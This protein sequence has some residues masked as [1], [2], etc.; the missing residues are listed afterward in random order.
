MLFLGPESRTG[1]TIFYPIDILGLSLLPDGNNFN[2]Q[3]LRI[4]LPYD[5]VFLCLSP[6]NQP[7]LS[8]FPRI[9]CL[10]IGSKVKSHCRQ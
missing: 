5:T 2:T 8:A 9:S 6:Q 10:S 3:N 7:I 1:I 4:T